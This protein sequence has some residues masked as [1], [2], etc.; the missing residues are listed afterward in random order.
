MA[1][2]KMT[3]D[4]KNLREIS[5]WLFTFEWPQVVDVSWTYGVL[6]GFDVIRIQWLKERPCKRFDG[7]TYW[8]L[9]PQTCDVYIGDSI[10]IKDK[11][12]Q[13]YENQD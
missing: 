11:G 10:V 9:E 8:A 3:F 12:I 1:E 5:D 6:P 13:V 4:G 7:V 2:T